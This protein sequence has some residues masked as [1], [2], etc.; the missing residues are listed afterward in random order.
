MKATFCTIITADFIHY[1]LSLYESLSNYKDLES[2]YI[3]VA[4]QK[5]S[6]NNLESKFSAI[7]ILYPEEVC[8]DEYGQQIQQK[9]QT[10]NM[11]CFRW[12]MKSVL[13]KYLLETGYDQVFFLDPD[14]YFY[15]SFDF[16]SQ[17]LE[18]NSVLLSP[19]WRASNPYDDPA[20]FAILLN[21]GLFNAGFI[22]VSKAGIPAMEWWAQVCAYECIKAPERGV[23]D[24]QA[25]L[26]LMPIYFEGVKILRHKGC[27]VANW[28]QVECKRTINQDGKVLINNQWE[29][30]FIHFTGS[31]VNGILSGKDHLLSSHLAQQQASLNKYSSWIPAEC[32]QQLSAQTGTKTSQASSQWKKTIR[33][34]RQLAGKIKRT[35]LR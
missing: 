15:N 7:Q 12:S 35:V 23:F 10:N 22:G 25:Y 18:G 16:L 3:L 6:F 27:N 26:N 14:L 9:Y 8:N 33:R 17:E 29:I 2:F 11:D 13:I 5:I 30:V 28:N 1:A 31:T 4:D 34:S 32:Q 19:H 24:D 20:N 21:K